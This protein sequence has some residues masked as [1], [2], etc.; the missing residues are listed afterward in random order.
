MTRSKKGFWR[1]V[2]GDILDH[3][4]RRLIAEQKAALA[5]AR[6]RR[7]LRFAKYVS[8]AARH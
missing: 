8:W 6:R 5:A 1:K 4:T 2:T 3:D 7:P